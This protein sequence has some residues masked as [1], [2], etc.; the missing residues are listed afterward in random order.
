M[1][2]STVIADGGVATFANGITTIEFEDFTVA[3]GE[4]A[5][6]GTIVADITKLMVMK[7]LL[8]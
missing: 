8:Y 4:N 3:D 6:E 5:I 1:D 7:H 2:G